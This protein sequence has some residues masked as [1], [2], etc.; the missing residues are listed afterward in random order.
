LVSK[1][2]ADAKSTGVS[3]TND[4]TVK[5]VALS[6]IV[7]ITREDFWMRS[8]GYWRP[9]STV[10]FADIKLTCTG[11]SPQWPMLAQDF[12]T[13]VGNITY[14]MEQGQTKGA[15]REGVIVNLAGS[16]KLRFRHVPF[17]V[18]AFPIT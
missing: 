17:Y 13:A 11:G 3:V 14:L 15:N 16:T 8:D 9:N 7:R 12:Q 18:S 2:E 6:V 4:V 5:P 1:E 10:A